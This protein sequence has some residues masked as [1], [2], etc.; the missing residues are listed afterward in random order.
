MNRG[1]DANIRGTLNLLEAAKSHDVKH[2]IFSG[3]AAV[4]GQTERTITLKHHARKEQVDEEAVCRPELWDGDPG[5]A[6]AILKLTTEKLC[7]MYQYQYDLPVT[8]FR[9]EYVFAG[10]KELED[11]ANIHVDDVV[12][13]F[14]LAAMNKKTY[15]QIYNVA[16]PTP[17]ISSK[18]LQRTLDWQPNTTRAFLVRVTESDVHI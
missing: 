13:A 16:Y 4:Y 12:N 3:S 2:F 11:H 14:I 5:P 10:E 18:K 9:L 7:L 15:G 17:Y 1:F 6:Y 8:V